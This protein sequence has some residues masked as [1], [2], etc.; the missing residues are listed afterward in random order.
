MSG[1]V[2]VGQVGRDLVLTVEE[3]PAAGSAA[4]VLERQELLG[5]KGANQAV[6]C[7]QLGAEVGLVGVVGT[8]PAGEAVLAQAAGDGIDVG[9]VVRRSGAPTALLVDLV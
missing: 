1:I 4:A 7:R 3:L 6:G 9:A 5:G 2:V 8:D